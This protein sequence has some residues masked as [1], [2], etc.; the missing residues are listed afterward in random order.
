MMLPA[1]ETPRSIS[2]LAT[3]GP[4]IERLLLKRKAGNI[5]ASA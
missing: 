5:K 1:S 2:R 4:S 3:P